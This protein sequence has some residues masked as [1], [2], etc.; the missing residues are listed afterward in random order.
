V[1]TDLGVPGK[2]QKLTHHDVIVAAE[3]TAPELTK[4]IIH[5]ITG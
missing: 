3:K 2:I 1:I 5:L 4:L